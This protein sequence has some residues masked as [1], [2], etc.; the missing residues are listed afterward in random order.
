MHSA[1]RQEGWGVVVVSVVW[2]REK[3]R[4]STLDPRRLGLEAKRLPGLQ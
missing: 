1:R 4:M 3:V 2:E